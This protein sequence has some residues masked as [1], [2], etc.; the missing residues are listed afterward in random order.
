LNEGETDLS[1]EQDQKLLEEFSKP[2]FK[3]QAFVKLVTQYQKRIYYFIRTQLH[4][5]DD[6]DDVVQEVFVKVWLNLHSFRGE[7]LLIHWIYRI[8][9]N[10]VYRFVRNKKRK[11][12]YEF[13]E[14]SNELTLPDPG[15]TISG[16]KAQQYLQ[17]AI[18]LL[19]ARQ[20][21]V[22]HLR[23]YDEMPYQEMSIVLETSV[24]ALKASYFHAARKVEEYLRSKA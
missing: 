1:K 12:N 21:Q 9:A 7:C 20:Q 17:E 16:E 13:L 8:A 22:F 5:H 2:E 14:E 19:P 23:Y 3:E 11:F 24:G 15:V 6:S 4:N 10:E 18:Q